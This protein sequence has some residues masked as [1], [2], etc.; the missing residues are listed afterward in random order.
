M[1]IFSIKSFFGKYFTLSVLSLLIFAQG[2]VATQI[3]APQDFLGFE[4]G[5]DYY[6]ADYSQIREYFQ[7]LADASPLLQVQELGQTTEGRPMIMAIITSS[8]NQRNLEKIHQAQA[9]LADP[10]SISEAEAIRYIRRGKVVVSINCS[11]HATE[12]G[13]SQMSMELAYRLLTLESSQIKE[14][15]ENVVILLIPAHNPDGIDM[16]VNWYRQ[17]LGTDYEGCR[18]PWLYQKYTGHDIN[19]DWFMLTQ[20]ETRLTVKKVYNVWRPQ[21]VFDLHQMGSSGARLFVPPYADPLDPNIDPILKA[22]MN[23]LGTTIASELIAQ[24]KAGVVVNALFDAYS[25]SRAYTNYHNGIRMLL[26]AAS[27]KIA[28]P[29]TQSQDDLQGAENYNPRRSSWN[30]PLPWTGGNWSLRDVVDYEM[31]ACLSLLAHAS[32][33]RLSYLRNTYHVA[34]NAITEKNDPFAVV[35][36]ANQNDPSATR[37]LVRVLQDG[38]VEIYQSSQPFTVDNIPFEKGALIIPMSQPYGSYA[39]TLLVLEPYPIPSQRKGTLFKPYDV[40]AHNLP[41]MFGVRVQEIN[42]PFDVEMVLVDSTFFAVGDVKNGHSIY[43]YLIDHRDNGCF[44]AISRLLVN[45]AEI[46]WLAEETKHWGEKFPIGT[47]WVKSAGSVSNLEEF[48]R[49]LSIDFVAAERLSAVQAFQLKAPRVGIYQSWLAPKDEGWTRWVLENADLPFIILHDADVRTGNLYDRFDVIVLPSQKAGEIISGAKPG[50]LPPEYCGGIGESG[51][52][53]LREF[54]QQGGTLITLGQAC[55]LAIKKFWIPVRNVL[56]DTSI[57][58]FSARGVLLRI[59]VDNQHPIGYG[60]LPESTAFFYNDPILDVRSGK[61]IAKYPLANPLLAGWMSNTRVFSMQA[62]VAEIPM[63]RGHVI[64]L[65]IHSQFRA[66]ARGTY[67]LLF[68]AIYFGGLEKVT[69]P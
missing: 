65:G 42:R 13:A 15:L 6:L 12:I 10:L 33:Y 44:R 58:D 34:K 56:D 2:A 23:A 57:K 64:L 69:I 20:N 7:L 28:S 63:A 8:S 31:E 46:Y 53:Q 54:V 41:L 21:I 32:N 60:M 25:P 55:E 45:E 26:E 29:I 14:I 24:G 22:E 66:Q 51:V 1:K 35:I 17:H 47:I 30:Y 38:L 36:P 27:P 5:A 18:M 48:A 59:L 39:R 49:E 4:I 61:V 37:D 43:G 11:I 16:V 9:A 52:E 68:N 50:R 40:T 62:A 3:P 67:K 19:R